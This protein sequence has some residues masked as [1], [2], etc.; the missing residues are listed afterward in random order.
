[1]DMATRDAGT[2]FSQNQVI[3]AL[4]QVSTFWIDFFDPS[5]QISQAVKPPHL[6]VRVNQLFTGAFNTLTI[7]FQDA[8]Q[9]AGQTGPN[10]APGVFENVLST[11]AIPKAD[12]FPGNDL[13]IVRIPNTGGLIGLGQVP[14]QPDTLS[15]SPLQR[16]VQFLYVCDAVPATGSLDAWLQIF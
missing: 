1:M 11:I 9:G 7:F 15:E 13:L 14:F 16:Y 2:I 12:L 8:A 10:A 6:H 5:H 3:N 4:S